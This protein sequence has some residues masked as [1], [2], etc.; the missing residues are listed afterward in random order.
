[1]SPVKNSYD[2]LW[3]EYRDARLPATL[4]S[5]I[6]RIVEYYFLQLCSYSIEDLRGR[7]KTHIGGDNK[8][9]RIADEILR[10]IYD[11]KFDAGDGINYAPDHDIPAYKDVFEVIFEAMSQKSHYLKMSGECE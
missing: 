8:K 5:V 7:V 9:Q 11:E 1:M 4:L 10:F 2:A 3:C 6:Q